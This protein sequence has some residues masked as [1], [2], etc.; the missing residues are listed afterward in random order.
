MRSRCGRTQETRRG[1]DTGTDDTAKLQKLDDELKEHILGQD[2]AIAS[3]TRAIKR[4]YAGLNADSK[5][6]G[7]FLFVGPTGVGKT[8]VT[9]QLSK[10]MGVESVY[11]RNGIATWEVTEKGEVNNVQVLS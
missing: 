6:I 2:E 5:P 1:T 8:E 10:V 9:K 4:S 3:L 11:H 7:S